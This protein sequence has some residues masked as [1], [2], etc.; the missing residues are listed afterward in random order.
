[1]TTDDLHELKMYSNLP[2]QGVT[3]KIEIGLKSITP[4]LG[5]GA[6]SNKLSEIGRNLGILAEYHGL[7]RILRKRDVPWQEGLNKHMFFFR[8]E[9]VN[10]IIILGCAYAV[11]QNFD[12]FLPI[13]GLGFAYIASDKFLKDIQKM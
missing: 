6:T 2:G 12:L 11:I 7:A 13:A 5:L 8:D 10:A 3:E 4:S 1:M 9:I